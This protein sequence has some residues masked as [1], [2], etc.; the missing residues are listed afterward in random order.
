MMRCHSSWTSP[1][2]D[3]GPATP[4]STENAVFSRRVKEL[5]VPESRSCPAYGRWPGTGM[6][7]LCQ[8][9]GVYIS[10]AS[11]KSVE[12]HRPAA[13]LSVQI[14]PYVPLRLATPHGAACGPMMADHSREP[15][16]DNEMRV[17]FVNSSSGRR[18]GGIQ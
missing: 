1:A 14:A 2:S 7:M 17:P 15:A 9:A 5:D 4:A 8:S 3:G 18:I 12:K 6:E 13:A 11:V 10:W 16:N